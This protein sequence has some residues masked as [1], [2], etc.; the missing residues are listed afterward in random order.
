[1]LISVLFSLVP[2]ASLVLVLPFLVLVVP[3][4]VLPVPVL[5]L[6]LVPRLVLVFQLACNQW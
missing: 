2:P 5:V 6:V 1:M 4:L 3:V